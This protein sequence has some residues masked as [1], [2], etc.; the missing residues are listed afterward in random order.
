M[1]KDHQKKVRHSTRITVRVF[2]TEI[3]G[4]LVLDFK[5]TWANFKEEL[6]ETMKIIGIEALGPGDLDG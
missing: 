5:S 1:A 6:E 4:D 3:N 2:W